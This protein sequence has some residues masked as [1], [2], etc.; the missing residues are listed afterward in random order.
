MLKEVASNASTFPNP[1]RGVMDFL[2]RIFIRSKEILHIF[3]IPSL[4]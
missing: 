4:A 3:L 1:S 2:K